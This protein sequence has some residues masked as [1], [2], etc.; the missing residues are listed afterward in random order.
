[1]TIVHDIEQ[2]TFEG[3]TMYTHE[4]LKDEESKRSTI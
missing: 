1:M 3:Y 4:E 2:W